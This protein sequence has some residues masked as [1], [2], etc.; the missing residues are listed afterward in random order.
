VTGKLDKEFFMYHASAARSPSFINSREICGRFQLPPGE[1]VIIPST[2]KPNEDG[3][4]LMRM[5]SEKQ[6]QSRLLIFTVILIF[7]NFYSNY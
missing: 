4:F 1:Y 7:I 5:Y 6:H 3:Q 2:F